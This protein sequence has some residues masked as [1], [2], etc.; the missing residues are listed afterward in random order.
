MKQAIEITELGQRVVPMRNLN[1]TIVAREATNGSGG[2]HVPELVSHVGLCLR[3]V[4]EEDGVLSAALDPTHWFKRLFTSSTIAGSATAAFR[5]IPGRAR[6]FG[7]SDGPSGWITGP[8]TS[9]TAGRL[10]PANIPTR[11]TRATAVGMPDGGI[12]RACTWQRRRRQCQLSSEL[13]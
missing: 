11:G 9:R 2:G 7:P 3:V 10:S 12:G 6:R 5:F 8:R 13:S 4:E 1:R